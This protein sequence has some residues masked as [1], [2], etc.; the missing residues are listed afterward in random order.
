MLNC[1]QAT[2]LMSQRMDK[3]LGLFQEMSLRLHLMMCS[4]C[5][6]F[7]KQMDFLRQGCRKFPSQDS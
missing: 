6:N 7:N 2:A 5:Q 1:K 4:G 3:K